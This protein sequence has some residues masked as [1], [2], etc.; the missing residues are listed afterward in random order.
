MR[1]LD[2]DVKSTKFDCPSEDSNTLQESQS[3]LI[4]NIDR[5]LSVLNDAL[6]ITLR[7]RQTR[8]LRVIITLDNSIHSASRWKRDPWVMQH[9]SWAT[10]S[11]LFNLIDCFHRYLAPSF[12]PWSWAPL[13]SIFSDSYKHCKS[14]KSGHDVGQCEYFSIIHRP[15]T[16]ES[17]LPRWPLLW[18]DVSCIGTTC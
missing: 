5:F 15:S 9:E 6:W 11:L 10:I 8:I 4:M 3:Q 14:H 17:H 2:K 18:F 1:K 16:W 7:H 13:H 12:L